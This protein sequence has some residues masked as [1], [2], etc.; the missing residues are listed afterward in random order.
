MEPALQVPR[1]N[2]DPFVAQP[3]FLD[4]I[5]PPTLPFPAPTWCLHQRPRAI[6]LLDVYKDNVLL[7]TVGRASISS[8]P[9]AHGPT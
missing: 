3:K 5:A 9:L 2:L 7:T 1:L 8:V 4:P 6:S